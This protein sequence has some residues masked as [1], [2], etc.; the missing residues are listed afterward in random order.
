M[1][2]VACSMTSASSVSVSWPMVLGAF[3]AGVV[4]TVGVTSIMAAVARRRERSKQD[5]SMIAACHSASG[6]GTTS[7][8]ETKEVTVDTIRAQYR[9]LHDTTASDVRSL[10]GGPKMTTHSI[11]IHDACMHVQ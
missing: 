1:C 6:G 9:I 2:H 11:S 10:S 8:N 7:S 5:K 3:G 4:A